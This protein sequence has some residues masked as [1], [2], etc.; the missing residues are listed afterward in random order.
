[1]LPC[2]AVIAIQGLAQ[3]DPIF[4]PQPYD[5]PVMLR[6][7][8]RAVVPGEVW[9]RGEGISTNILRVERNDP[10]QSVGLVLHLKLRAR[11]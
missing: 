7:G 3:M 8:S 9:D 1:M 2:L 5:Q 4:V 11:R 10:T 6:A